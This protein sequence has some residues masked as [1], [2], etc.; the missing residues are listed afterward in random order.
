VSKTVNALK[1][2][3]LG[4][5]SVLTINSAMAV[6][7][8]DPPSIDEIIVTTPYER[9]QF[10]LLQSTSVLDEND[11]KQRLETNL[12]ETLSSLAG[13]SSSYFG[14][15]ASRPIIR[16][17]GAERLRVLLDGIGTI[18]ASNT[19]PDHAVASEVITAERI[20]VLRGPASLLFGSSAAGGVVNVIDGR[21]PSDVPD[22]IEG[23]FFTRYG[24]NDD[25]ASV[26]GSLTAG[27]AERLALHVDGFFKDTGNIKV[28]GFAATAEERAEADEDEQDEFEEGRISNTD[29]ES[30]GGTFGIS[31]FFEGGY[32]GA[33]IAY[34]ESEYG[35]PIAEEHHGEEEGE[36]EEEEGPIRIDLDQLRLDFKAGFDLSGFFNQAKFRFSYADYEHAELEGDEIGTTFSNKGYEGRFELVQAPQGNWKGAV[37]IQFRQ[38]DFEAVGAEAFIPANDTLQLGLF[39]LEEYEL[40][41]WIFEASGRIEYVDV[42]QN[43]LNFN[44]DFTPISFALG[45]S[46]LWNENIRGGI[47]IYRTERA[48]SAEEL[49]SFGP[50]FATSSFEV[51][52]PGLE[53]EVAWGG[54]ATL[55]VDANRFDGSV[56]V[57][58]T[59]YDD[60]IV[61]NFTGEEEDDLPVFAFGQTD[62]RFFGVEVEA[63]ATLYSGD[64]FEL[65]SDLAA[66]FVRATDRGSNTPLPRIPA[67]SALIGLEGQTEYVN[68]RVEVE[69]VDDQDRV[70]QFERPTDGYALLNL[71]VTFKP[72]G[73]EH[74][75]SLVFQ[76]RNLTDEDARRHTSFL[77]EILPLQGRNFRFAARYS[78]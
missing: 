19:S 61:Q 51:G 47:Q 24:T 27:I 50:H 78:F 6:E 18:D 56:T 38:R 9:Q 10:D 57:F 33:S 75:L 23:G 46:H 37:G 15:G 11:I 65:I 43:T 44:R 22:E 35:V 45:A 8:L 66:D 54:E 17:L 73:D 59:D 3:L 48:P 52:N 32:I 20:E 13:V 36:E 16:G 62:A 30:Y 69:L 28:P 70:S 40:E 77:K 2:S 21:I 64:G 60:F 42:E 58:F 39:A 49:F 12:G 5:L 25:E 1:L 71:G 34:N 72:F 31:G 53:K 4:S 26:A 74:D 63:Q 41:H 7:P 67:K 14:P 68:G 76:A 29:T 55:R